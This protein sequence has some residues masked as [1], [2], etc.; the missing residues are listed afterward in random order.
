MCECEINCLWN[1]ISKLPDK[2]IWEIGQNDTLKYTCDI[3]ALW[4]FILLYYKF[5]CLVNILN[6]L[7]IDV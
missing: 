7:L 3:I 6:L 5:T 4:V 1:Y 2:C